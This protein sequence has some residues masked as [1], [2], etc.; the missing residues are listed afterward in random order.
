MSIVMSLC[1]ASMFIMAGEAS[2]A[3]VIVAAITVVLGVV[4]QAIESRSH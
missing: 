4:V 3:S 1:F 2:V